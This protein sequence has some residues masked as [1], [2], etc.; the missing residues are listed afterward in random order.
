LRVQ[1]LASPQSSGLPDDH[2]EELAGAQDLHHHQDFT[3]PKN[4][5]RL[6]V[7][8]KNNALGREG[9]TGFYGVTSGP[10]EIVIARPVAQR[11]LSL[12]RA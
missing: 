11:L 4:W 12:V 3:C 7:L 1:S 5:A 9:G 8:L 6:F 2:P 10:G